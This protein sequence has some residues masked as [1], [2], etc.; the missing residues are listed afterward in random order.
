MIPQIFSEVS[1]QREFDW[2]PQTNKGISPTRRVPG[3]PSYIGPLHSGTFMFI[4][5]SVGP[6]NLAAGGSTCGPVGRLAPYWAANT[7]DRQPDE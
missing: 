3:E 2:R 7:I 4:I 5:S 6:P 1:Q